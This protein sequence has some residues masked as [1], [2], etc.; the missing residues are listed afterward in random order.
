MAQSDPQGVRSEQT[1]AVGKQSG[2]WRPP[3]LL[4]GLAI[5]AMYAAIAAMIYKFYNEHG[6]GG[7]IYAAVFSLAIFSLGVL[8][9]LYKRVGRA[10]EVLFGAWFYFFGWAFV[11]LVPIVLFRQL[12]QYVL[13][14]FSFWFQI[15]S[16]VLWGLLLACALALIITEENRKWLFGILRKAGGFAPVVYSLNVLMIAVIFFASLTYLLLT[17]HVIAA[18][19]QPVSSERLL[20]FFTWHFLDAIPA[21]QVN[22]TLHWKEPWTYN[23][24][25]VGAILLLFKVVVIVPVLAA[26][27]GYWKYRSGKPPQRPLNERRRAAARAA[28]AAKPA[29]ARARFKPHPA[30]APQTAVRNTAGTGAAAAP[31]APGR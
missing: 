23:S 20:D 14:E 31:P 8:S 13:N 18:G 7:L 10:I 19:A 30:R 4:G 27:A 12:S 1:A 24:A 3:K 26:F 28:A 11:T 17:H 6:W 29:R 15:L 5:L 21:L 22:Q 2:A 16:F 25:T 9:S